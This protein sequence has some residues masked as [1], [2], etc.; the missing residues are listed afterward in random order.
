MPTEEVLKVPGV[1]VFLHI[2]RPQSL[3]FGGSD[4]RHG[5]MP[6]VSDVK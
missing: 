5:R 4:P 1:V 6:K 2:C 3:D